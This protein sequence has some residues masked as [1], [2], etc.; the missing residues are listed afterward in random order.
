M[1]RPSRLERARGRRLSFG[2]LLDAISRTPSHRR[3]AVRCDS[4][5]IPA[6]LFASTAAR[7]SR[8]NAPVHP[9]VR[10]AA[11]DFKSYGRRLAHLPARAARTYRSHAAG[12]R[13]ILA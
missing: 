8:G 6:L 11:R 10:T 1:A 2:V 5:A 7:I 4:A 13:P 9:F 3:H 12:D